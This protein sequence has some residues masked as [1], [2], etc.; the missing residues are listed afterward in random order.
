[1]ESSFSSPTNEI[2]SDSDIPNTNEVEILEPSEKE[3]HTTTK[4]PT[5]L[6]YNSESFQF[7]PNSKSSIYIFSA[8]L[9][10]RTLLPIDANKD[11]R[12]QIACITCNYKKIEP[13]KRFQA[14]NFQ[15]HYQRNHPIIAYNTKSEKNR[16]KKADHLS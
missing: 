13:V 3:R 9:F 14:S 12:V 4:K 16:I 6:N 7:E 15:R 2:S 11:R 10:T 8:G 1:M 5:T